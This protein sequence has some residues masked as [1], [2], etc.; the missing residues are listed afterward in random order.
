L[1][2]RGIRTDP[3]QLR[4]IQKERSR[5][6]NRNKGVSGSKGS[7]RQQP[8]A[9]RVGCSNFQKGSK[10]WGKEASK[11]PNAFIWRIPKGE[12]LTRAYGNIYCK[13]REGVCQVQAYLFN[14]S[15]RTAGK[16]RFLLEEKGKRETRTAEEG[17]KCIHKTF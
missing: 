15:E 11:S 13:Q 8:A 17:S 2:E 6:R 5:E 14:Q 4:A 1:I 7:R 9:W 3:G 12:G 10:R 16:R